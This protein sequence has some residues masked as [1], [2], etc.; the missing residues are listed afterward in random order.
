MGPPYGLGVTEEF[1]AALR[2]TPYYLEFETS[3]NQVG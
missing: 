1:E 3:V 2:I